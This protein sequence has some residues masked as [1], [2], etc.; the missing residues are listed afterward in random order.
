MFYE[1]PIIVIYSTLSPVY[2]SDSGNQN[3]G[4]TNNNNTGNGGSP[5]ELPFLTNPQA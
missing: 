2:A 5:I 1:P 3:S 4:N